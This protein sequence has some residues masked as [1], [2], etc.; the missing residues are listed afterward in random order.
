MAKSSLKTGRE[1]YAAEFVKADYDRAVFTDNPYIDSLITS[2]TALSANVWAIQ[3]RMKI[4]EILLEK[5]G[6]VTRDMIEQYQPTAE[7]AALWRKERN[8]FVA[9]VNDPFKEVGDLPYAASIDVPHP[10]VKKAL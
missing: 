9:E 5:N 6:A 7:E 2:L 3:R 8:S 1:T 10:G 4:V